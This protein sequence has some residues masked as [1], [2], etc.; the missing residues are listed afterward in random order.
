MINELH[1]YILSS[2]F[3]LIYA[4]KIKR[5]NLG[6]LIKSMVEAKGMS[7]A[8]FARL[9]GIHRQNLNKT[10]FEKSGIDTNLLCVISEVLEC[11]LFDYFKSDEIVDKKEIKATLVIEKGREKQ[12]KTLCFV[13]SDKDSEN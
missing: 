5:I 1:T 3:L 12:E 4:M 9:I 6:E 7:Q 10:V 13:F 2:L 11:N 8:Q